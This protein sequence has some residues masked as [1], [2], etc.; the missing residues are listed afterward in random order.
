MAVGTNGAIRQPPPGSGNFGQGIKFP[1]EYDSAGRL[2]LSYGE[3]SVKESL[4]SI[5]RTI[6]GERP[7]QPDYGAGNA[8]F[9]PID[10]GRL[11]LDLKRC[12]QEHEPRVDAETLRVLSAGPDPNNDGGLLVE[13]EYTT[14]RNATAQILTYPMFQPPTST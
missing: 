5:G 7:M 13:I 9:D 8:L 2:A 6:R 4:I 10:S 12:I 1:M 14:R 3:Q 11:E